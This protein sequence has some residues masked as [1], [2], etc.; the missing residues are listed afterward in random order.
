MKEAFFN[1]RFLK[2]W[3]RIL[4]LNA[5]SQV[6]LDPT[7]PQYPRKGRCSSDMQASHQF[8][9]KQLCW[10]M[11][12][13]T[14]HQWVKDLSLLQAAA[15]VTGVAQVRCCWGAVWQLQFQ[16]LLCFHCFSSF[17]SQQTQAVRQSFMS[18]HVEQLVKEKKK[19]NESGGE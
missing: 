19:S 8:W 15:Q 17:L 2:L 10:N 18:L 5:H 4:F 7:P 6:L 14:L 3:S 12:L 13:H 11:H 16:F 1:H 9:G